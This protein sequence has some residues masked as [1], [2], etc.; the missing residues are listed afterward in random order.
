MAG[1]VF[2]WGIGIVIIK[3]TVSPFLVVS[4][5]R[6][7]FSIPVLLVAWLALGHRRL[8]WRVAGVGGVLFAGHQVLHFSSLRYST[9][10]VVTILFSL[11][12]ILVGAFSGRITG[13]KT[14]TR[15]YA[16]SALAI[17]GCAIL[18]LASA[19]QPEATA[20]GTFLA[21][22]NLLAWSAYYL[23]TKRARSEVHTISWLLVMTMV[24]GVIIGLLA[25][26]TRQPFLD[27]DATEWWYM[28]AIALGP[29]TLGHFL[30]TW[31]QPRIH[32][33][34]SSSLNLGVPIVASLGAAVFLNEAFGPLHALVALIALGGALAAMR[35]LPPPVT[36]VAA[37]RFGEVAT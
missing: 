14:T 3:L 19:G 23:A 31:A 17:G 7:V 30:V 37:E 13:D 27:A 11:Q 22:L 16:W 20:L 33:A 18:V 6:H 15:F 8:P 32:V 2:V 4:F 10:A 29:G 21:T 28:L 36:E 1:G 12:P 24:S 25:L 9:A 34:A 35:C 26:V 5:Y